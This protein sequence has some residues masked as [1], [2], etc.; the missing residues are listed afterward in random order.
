MITTI[1][2][3][4]LVLSLLVFVHE[5]GHFWTAKKLGVKSDEFG[6]GFPPRICGVYKNN[7]GK[8]KIVWGSK[9][10]KDAKDTVYSIN[11]IPLGGFVK[12]K[13]EDGEDKES[14]DSFAHKA[15][16][17]RSAI[18]SAGVIMN[19]LLAFVLFS[20]GFMVGLPQQVDDNMRNNL[21]VGDINVQITQVV[22]GTPAE[23]AGV[24]I[25]DII[26]S[27]NGEAME[28]VDELISFT[29][30]KEGET[31]KYKMLRGSEPLDFEIIPVKLKETENVGI[32]VAIAEVALVKY[33]WYSAIWMGLKNTI[34]LVWAIFLAFIGLIQ[35]LIVGNDVSA[36]VGGPIK[37][38][39]LTGHFAQLG[40][41]YLLQFTA[42]LSI[43]LA[44]INILPFPAL[45]GGRLLFLLIEK[46]KGSPVNENFE[47]TA[48]LIGFSLLMLLMALIIYGDV[49]S[50]M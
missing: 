32:G 45:D 23:K 48:H 9:D 8:W 13:G 14:E 33:P 18:L 44:I 3:F 6:F 42:M 21:D 10:V 30:D 25:G 49:V 35:S 38:A 11:I 26:F 15:I 31:L 12:I 22:P 40:F 29:G 17:K 2:L 46:I 39:S 7:N 1:I 37:I 19:V 36:Q 50:V 43:N 24:K 4:I 5:F 47:K 16:W 28:T 27:V 34:F 41:V 20:I